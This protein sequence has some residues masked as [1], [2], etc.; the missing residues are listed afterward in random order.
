MIVH[1]AATAAVTLIDTAIL[2][3]QALAA[4]AAF[5][6]LVVAWS[7]ALCGAPRVKAARNHL[8][9]RVTPERT[10]R[11][12]EPTRAAKRRHTPAWAHTEPYTY[13]EAA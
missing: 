11:A 13:E 5:V 7:V 2:W 1:D 3:A 4:G 6:F 9:A 12:P 8:N 10:P